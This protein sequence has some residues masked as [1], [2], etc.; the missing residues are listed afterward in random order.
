MKVLIT[1]GAG[2]IGSHVAETLARRGDEIT[3]L[4]NFNDFYDPAIKR[5]NAS[6][7]EGVRVV[8]GDIRDAELMASLFAETHFDGVIH[9]AAMAGVRL[10]VPRSP[11]ARTRK[12]RS[13]SRY[14]R[15]Y[16]ELRPIRAVGGT[17]PGWD[18]EEDK[19]HQKPEVQNLGDTTRFFRRNSDAGP[20]IPLPPARSPQF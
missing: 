4:D 18:P 3:I 6:E 14:S 5:R 10:N 7:L 1:G 11:Q 9:L 20:E 13:A 19:K 12:R 2:F 17:L 16:D 15:R 8:E